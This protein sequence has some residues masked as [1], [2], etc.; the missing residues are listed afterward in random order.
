M[1]E[2]LIRRAEK[3]DI[4]AICNLLEQV[5]TVH[6][7]GRPDVFKPN[8]RKYTDDELKTLISSSETPIFVAENTT[9]VLGYAFCII[10]TTKDDNILCDM[11]TLYIDDLCVDEGARGLSIGRSLYNYVKDYAKNIGCYNLTLNVWECNPGAKRFYE[12]MGLMPQKTIMEA[13]L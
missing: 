8:S 1:S 13:I 5:L 12:K 6:H 11:K 9:R 3:T 2:I 7:N 4:P 10:K